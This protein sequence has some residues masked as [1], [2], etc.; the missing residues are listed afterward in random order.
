MENLSKY[1]P[2]ELNKMI[3]DIKIKHDTLK[4]ELIKHTYEA[5]ELE[6]KINE[7]IKLL[8]ETENQYVLLI[9]EMEKR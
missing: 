2:I 7:K 8:T 9:E 1:T 3:N 4:Q 5:E 6:K